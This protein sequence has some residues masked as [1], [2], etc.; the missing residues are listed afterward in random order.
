MRNGAPRNCKKCNIKLSR[1]NQRDVCSTCEKNLG[2]ANKKVLWDIIN[3]I[4]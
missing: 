3:E 2:S 1:Y 4:G